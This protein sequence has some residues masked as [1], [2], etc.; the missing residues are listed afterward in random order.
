[1]KFPLNASSNTLETSRVR[2]WVITIVFSLCFVTL[3]FRL[4]SLTLFA[5][6]AS[7]QSADAKQEQTIFKRREIVDRNGEII[8]INLSTASLYADP[9]YILD[10]VEA[11]KKLHAVLPEI[12]HKELLSKFMSGKRFIWIKRN[13]TPKEQYAIN[14][15]GIP[16]LNFEEEEKRVYPKGNLFAHTLGYVGVDGKGLAGLEKYLDRTLSTPDLSDKP[17]QVSLDVRIQGVLHEELSRYKEEFNAVGAMGLVLDVKT[18]EVLALSSLPDFDPQNPGAASDDSKFNRVTLGVFEMGSTF[19]VL[20]TAM[21]LDTGVVS[22]RGGYDVSKP[23]RVGRFTIHDYHPH[24]GWYSVPEILMESSNIGTAKMAMDIG[25][26]MQQYYLKQMGMFSPTSI[27]VPEKGAPMYPRQWS[28][29][30]TMTVSYGHGIA[31][32]PLH[33]ATAVA[34]VVNGGMQ[35]KPTLLKHAPGERIAGASIISE[36]TSRIMRQMLRLVVA[37]GTGK[38][39]DAEGYMV[40][41]KTGSAEKV[42]EG[43]RYKKKA[44]VSSFVGVFPIH[45]PRYLVLAMLDEPK[46]DRSTGYF[47]T[48]GQVAAPV[49]KQVVARIAPILG[50][51][52]VDKNS[53]EIR[54]HFWVEL[55]GDGKEVAAY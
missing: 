11:A 24:N 38:K 28:E 49:I 3:L 37:Q 42:G 16:G 41:G 10:P 13:L 25:G 46:G 50:V 55:K 27:E 2:L 54:R 51:M 12:S 31:V 30:S 7:D 18:G 20:T 23:I 5:T 29:V 47:A 15:L 4:L 21:A 19:K 6:E 36:K 8:A 32:T 9:K 33:L 34:T 1:M 40:G 52:P 48:G 39:A 43:G 22:V 35:Y 53:E 26:D 44:L 45:Q 17:L 14:A